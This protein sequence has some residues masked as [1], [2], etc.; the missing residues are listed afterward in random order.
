MF[1]C[2]GSIRKYAP[3]RRKQS[4]PRRCT[5]QRSDKKPMQCAYGF[6]FSAPRAYFRACFLLQNNR[7]LPY[8]NANEAGRQIRIV[9]LR[10]IDTK[11]RALPPKTIRTAPVHGK[12]RQRKRPVQCAYGFRFSAPGAY[13]RACFLLQNNRYLPYKNA[14]EAGRQIKIDT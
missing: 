4:A 3:S 9:L 14:N 11:I 8:K 6:R 2:D 12:E 7:Y 5:V 10:R 1:C 13:F